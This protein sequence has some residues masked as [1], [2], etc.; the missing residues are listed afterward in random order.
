MYYIYSSGYCILN[1]FIA[2]IDCRF[3][4]GFKNQVNTIKIGQY[5]IIFI[6]FYFLFD[7]KKL[8]SEIS[9]IKN[10]AFNLS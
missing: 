7:K 3:H 8:F 4:R 10:V 2:S 1:F 5:I 6:D 9:F